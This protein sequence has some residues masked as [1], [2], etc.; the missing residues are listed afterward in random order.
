MR[1]RGLK[2]FLLVGIL[3]VVAAA[4]WIAIDALRPIHIPEDPRSDISRAATI[5]YG[6]IT[7]TDGHSRI[8]I[9]EIWKQPPSDHVPSI[10]WS[11]RSPLPT[12]AKP[13]SVILCFHHGGNS[14]YS[15]LS[16]QGDRIPAANLSLQNL[17]ALCAATPR[18]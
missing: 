8:V 15:I 9:D 17:K 5:A 13:D 3:L 6:H 2:V 10:G 1:L 7:V 12:D 11:M 18:T 4:V 16:V 14:P